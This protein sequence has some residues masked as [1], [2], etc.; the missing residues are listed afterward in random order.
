VRDVGDPLDIAGRLRHLLAADLEELPVDPDTG[1]RSADDRRGLGD[2]VLVV[3]EHVVDAAGV[4]VEPR[5]EVL[6][7]HRRALEVPAW[8]ALAPGRRRALERAPRAGALPE[9]EVGRV[10]LVGLDVA[11]MAGPQ[12][13]E[14]V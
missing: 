9:R 1:R 2:L 10:A 3:G 14:R 5:P 11:A 8:A 12:R 7:G 6:E 4:D 13:V